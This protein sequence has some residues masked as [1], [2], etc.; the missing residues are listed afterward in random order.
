MILLIDNY[1]SFSYNLV[2]RF[3]PPTSSFRQAPAI[4]K[5]PVS[6]RKPFKGFRVKSRSLASAW[7]IRPSAK[8]MAAP[9]PTQNA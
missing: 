2:Q 9:L 4:Q 3:I 6:A 8:P 7:D 5:T 1:D